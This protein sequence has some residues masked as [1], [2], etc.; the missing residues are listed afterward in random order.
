MKELRNKSEIFGD[1]ILDMLGKAIRNKVQ[2]YC[3]KFYEKVLKISQP[4]I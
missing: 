2:E 3:Q 4:A 1:F